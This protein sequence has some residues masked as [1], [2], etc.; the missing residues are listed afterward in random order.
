M[1][2]PKN[3][4][5]HRHGAECNHTCDHDHGCVVRIRLYQPEDYAALKAI[6]QAGRI[7]MDDCDSAA[8]L[9]RN[10][11][12]RPS[13]YRVFTVDVEGIQ[14]N[15]RASGK[16]QVV[17][18]AIVT[19]DGHRAYLYHFAV[20]PDFR[21]LGIGRALLET[22]EAQARQFGAKQMRLSARSDGSRKVAQHIYESS[23]WI[24]E[25]EIWMY[26]KDLTKGQRV[27]ARGQKKARASARA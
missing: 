15:D 19:F 14:H 10:I 13:G 5:A 26:R 27:I 6:W 3:A 4:T 21:G 7:H 1:K 22:C 25:D 12:Q 2:K 23:G 16:A 18:G 20:H 17:G 24:H 8:A 9:A 11:K